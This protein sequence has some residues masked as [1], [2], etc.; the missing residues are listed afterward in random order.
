MLKRY[1]A[2]SSAGVS[3]EL[4]KVAG[5]NVSQ[6]LRGFFELQKGQKLGRSTNVAVKSGGGK[7]S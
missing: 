4:L 5:A 6:Y 7:S 2:D 1:P 3:D